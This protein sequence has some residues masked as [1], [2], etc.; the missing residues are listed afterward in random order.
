MCSSAL[1]LP[2]APELHDSC[3]SCECA[4]HAQV[5]LAVDGI[6]LSFHPLHPSVSAASSQLQS[7]AY[8]REAAHRMNAEQLEAVQRV[9]AMQDYVVMLGMPGT[10]KTTTIVHIIKV[11][12]RHRH[13]GHQ[14]TACLLP[15]HLLYIR[16]Q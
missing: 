10:G 2:L 3:R 11:G 13:P 15:K 6:W 12:L 1:S 5:F 14:R 9:L 16:C 8:L 7:N 4:V